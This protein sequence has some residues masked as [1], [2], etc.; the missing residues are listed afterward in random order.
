ML[1]P[2][3]PG[4]CST[5]CISE[6]TKDPETL[7]NMVVCCLHLGKPSSRYLS[8]LKL[9]Q[10]DHMFVKPISAGEAAFDRAVH[11]SA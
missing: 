1:S 10:A 4:G 11:T 3:E 5:K 9:S 8:Q 2:T 7:A 6:D